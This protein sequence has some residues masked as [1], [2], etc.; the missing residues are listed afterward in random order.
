MSHAPEIAPAH[1]RVALVGCGRISRN[2]V[3]AISQNPKL[4]L[5]AVCDIDHERARTL[6]EKLHIPFY[7]S[8]DEMLAK[9]QFDLISICTPTGLHSEMGIAAAEKGIHVL[10]EKPIAIN[11]KQCD[12]LIEACKRN[13][14]RL[15][16]VKQN[17][18]NT[19]LQ[20]LNTAVHK[21]RFGR[22]FMINS[23]VRWN[24]T[25]DYYNQAPWRGTRAMDGGA[26]LNQASHYVDAVQ[27]LGGPVKS[28]VGMTRTFNHSIE[29]E[30]SGSAILDFESGALGTLEITMCTYRQNWEGSITIVGERGTAKVGGV[31]VNKIEH[32]DFDRYEDDDKWVNQASYIPPNVYGFGHIGYYDAVTKSLRGEASFNVDGGE[33]R[34]SL[35]IVMGIYQSS[36]TGR[37]VSLPLRSND[38]PS[39]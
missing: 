37:K 22:I 29:M 28:V 5:V 7:T 36:E 20:L 3:D 38:V 2:H 19:T 15:F 33:A 35:E 10:S 27:W 13:K 14:V 31:A 34:K 17:R 1:L 32:W 24:R 21:G 16:V 26:F 6:G 25:Q 8:Y 39:A 9:E 18:L 12:A 11:L 23:T 30:D 4:K